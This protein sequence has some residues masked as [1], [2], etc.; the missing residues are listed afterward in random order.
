MVAFG[1]NMALRLRYIMHKN[2]WRITYQRNA[3]LLDAAILTLQAFSKLLSVHSNL[4]PCTLIQ[5]SLATCIL[6]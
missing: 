3:I 1:A 6:A 4:L 2:L 5:L